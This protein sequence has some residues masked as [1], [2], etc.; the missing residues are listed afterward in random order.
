[1]VRT[2]AAAA[3]L[4]VAD[5]FWKSSH[6]RSNS[7][8]GVGLKG[9]PLVLEATTPMISCV[10]ATSAFHN[11]LEAYD[12]YSRQTCNSGTTPSKHGQVAVDDA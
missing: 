2:N 12:G 1:M 11:A 5:A 7:M 8:N 4:L 3:L 9:K 10:H 6:A